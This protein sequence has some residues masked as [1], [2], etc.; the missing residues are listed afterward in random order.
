MLLG[1]STKVFLRKL[2]E[3]ISRE[4]QRC[5]IHKIP[6]K[7]LARPPVGSTVRSKT[8]RQDMAKML[9]GLQV[10]SNMKLLRKSTMLREI[11]REVL[12]VKL[13]H[14]NKPLKLFMKP[15][16]RFRD[17]TVISRKHQE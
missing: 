3:S 14:Q 4:F 8:Q 12:L 1:M 10:N 2:R 16:E 15:K 17:L 6:L 5:Q 9:R 13:K 7:R 11:L